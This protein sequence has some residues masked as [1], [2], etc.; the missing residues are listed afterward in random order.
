MTRLTAIAAA[1][2]TAGVV[3]SA[4]WLQVTRIDPAAHQTYVEALLRAEDLDT[5]LD[6]ELGRAHLGQVT[7]Y[8]GLVAVLDRIDANRAHLE[9]VPPWS[10]L[11]PELAA[12]DEARRQKRRLVEHFKTEHAVLRNS[13]RLL[14]YLADRHPDP[15]AAT[16]TVAAV[17]SA[18]TDPTPTRR[19]RAA[20]MLREVEGSDLARHGATVLER[21]PA[22]AVTVGHLAE[23]PVA[24]TARAALTSYGADHDLAL[25]RQGTQTLG[26]VAFVS[27]AVLFACIAAI[28]RLGRARDREAELA[29]LRS[30]FVAMASHEFRT[31][32]SVI[33]S[34]NE[35]LRRYGDRWDAERAQTHLS[36]VSTSVR[37]M[38]DMLDRV[39]VIGRNDETPLRYQP[40]PVAVAELLEA[41]VAEVR[42]MVGAE[43]QLNVQDD[44]GPEL[45]VLDGRQLR[46]MLT[47]LLS[48]ACKYSPDRSP[49]T[50]T[51]RREGELL[52]LEVADQGIGI[53][54]REQG[55]LFHPF[56]RCSN[57]ADFEG[58]GLGLAMV[59]AWVDAHRG[60][61]EVD[62]AVGQGTRII[63]CIPAEAP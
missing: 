30:R 38:K 17:L 8:D 46:H 45:L 35:L 12:Y 47:N 32:L 61:I 15:P 5:R 53:P 24:E 63:V 43:R 11:Q 7:H 9:Q 14:P 10:D 40:S 20:A 29:R 18:S 16:R 25:A 49:V 57:A 4:T 1:L 58:T 3:V 59:K 19:A 2:S 33:L 62:S 13:V 55:E 28:L 37:E 48:N 60:T 54:R 31:P 6:T 36:R 27:F 26:V 56:H 41:A 39:L 22:L 50:L 23:A 21:Q 34:S 42:S 44:S 51:A 52:R